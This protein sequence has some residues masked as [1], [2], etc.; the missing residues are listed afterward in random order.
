MSSGLYPIRSTNGL[1]AKITSPNPHNPPPV[2]PPSSDLVNPNWPPQSPRMPLRMAKPT[3]FAKMVINPANSSQWA[4]GVA[5]SACDDDVTDDDFMEN[6][7]RRGESESGS[8][9]AKYN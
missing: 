2:M 7:L 4:L 8:R 1:T 3:P 6:G 9:V 5:A